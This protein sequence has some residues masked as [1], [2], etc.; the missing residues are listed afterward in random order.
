MNPVKLVLIGAGGIGKQWASGI[1]KSKTVRLAG[2][3]DTD[4][5][6][7]EDIAKQ[8]EGCVV[9]PDWQTAAKT[10][11]DGFIVG[12]PHN[13]LASISKGLLEAGKHVLCEKPAGIS[14]Q[15]V[16]AN[17]ALARGKNLVYMAGFNHR[18]H[19]AFAEAK[20]RFATGEI[21]EMMFIRARHGFGGR[22]GYEKEWRFSKAIGGG[23]EFI[24]QGMHMIDMARWFMG[25]FTDVRGFA[26]N[27]FW[28]GEVEDNGFALLRTADRK[29][30]QIH[31]SWTQWDWLHSFEIFGTKGYLL[32]SGLD[33]RYHG[34]EQLTVGHA[35]ARSGKFPT[36]EVIVYKEESKD[37]SLRREAEDFV[38]ALRGEGVAIPRGEDAKAVLEIVETIYKNN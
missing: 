15:E 1:A 35:D 17:I 34:P 10:D 14:S 9:Y 21:G 33:Q 24:D 19:P 32:I 13:L 12:V 6:R 18:Y 5:A 30:A 16:A 7:A 27:F 22:P 20:K 11:A 4:T 29:V 2:V 31:V 3:V 36:E 28:G 37:D 38:R 8:H 23:G 25:E 26:E